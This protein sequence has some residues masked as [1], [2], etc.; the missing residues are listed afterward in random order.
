MK[1]NSFTMFLREAIRIMNEKDETEY[2]RLTN[3]SKEVIA[4][5]NEILVDY[6]DQ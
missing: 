3:K 4:L 6:I 5:L 2:Q 1:E